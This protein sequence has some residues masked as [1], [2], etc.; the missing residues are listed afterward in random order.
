MS[1]KRCSL[2]GIAVFTAIMITGS[3]AHA[4]T[5][6]AL[7]NFQ[8]MSLANVWNGQ[9]PMPPAVHE[10]AGPNAGAASV[11]IVMSTVVTDR[12]MRVDDGKVRVIRPNGSAAWINKTAIRP[13]R[14]ASNPNAQCWV[15][16]KE[17]GMILTDLHF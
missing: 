4:Q 1:F 7:P 13:W 14:V 5:E 15:V 6:R 8:C 16:R 11:G 12:P 10:Y 9:G 17:N 2:H 3:V